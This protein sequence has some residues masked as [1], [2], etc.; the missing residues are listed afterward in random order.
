MEFEQKREKIADVLETVG[1]I[2]MIVI[3]VI[4]VGWA[5]YSLYG[6]I[7]LHGFEWKQLLYLF[8]KE[9][10]VKVVIK[11]FGAIQWIGL[12][13]CI[14]WATL[15]A[16]RISRQMTPDQDKKARVVSS[17][18]LTMML[19]SFVMSVVLLI[20]GKTWLFYVPLIPCLI[21]SF[22]N[23]DDDDDD[24]KAKE[25]EEKTKELEQLR[26]RVE[27]LEKELAETAAQE[28]ET[29]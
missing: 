18:R 2:I 16:G 17:L 5:A 14:G 1:A 26:Q 20:M 27:E 6:Y 15:M 3:G 23:S 22:G 11:F 21:G 29:E 7:N 10:I 8:S 24:Q 19:L 9:G 4:F 12:L 25:L 13:F 28:D